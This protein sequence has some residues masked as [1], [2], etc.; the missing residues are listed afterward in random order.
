MSVEDYTTIGNVK[1]VMGVPAGDTSQ[2]DLINYLIPI[3]SRN[4]DDYCHRHFYPLEATEVYDYT[5]EWKM[6][7]RGDLLEVTEFLN[8]DGTALDSGDYHLYPLGGP[9]YSWVEVNH[10]SAKTFRFGATTTQQC[11]SV[12]GTW[13]YLKNGE[14]PASIGHACTAWIAYIIKLGKNAGV[15]SKTIGDYQITFANVMETL[16][17]GPPNECRAYLDKFVRRRY[18]S[19]VRNGL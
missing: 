8:G 19:N 4:I 3:I 5:D 1:T 14:T 6:F 11:I 2:D 13:G 18:A 16:G 7:L 9:P 15:K 12:T 10:G 17:D